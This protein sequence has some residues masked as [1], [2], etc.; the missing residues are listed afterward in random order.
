MTVLERSVLLPILAP[1]FIVGLLLGDMWDAPAGAVGLLTL[2][3]VLLTALSVSS[4]VS[5]LP[6]LAIGAALLGLL[7]GGLVEQPGTQLL[8]YHDLSG[9]AV[10]GLVIDQP[11]DH[12]RV[13]SFRLKVDQVRR[14]SDASWREAV[15]DVRVTAIPTL[16]LAQVRDTPL[17][18]Y[19]DRLELRGRFE[20]PTP[21]GEFD[22]PAFL[23][24]QGISTVMAFP[25]VVLI[26]E[27]GG[28]PVRRWLSSLRIALSGSL[29]RV[30]SEPQ[31]AFGQA[32]LLGMRDGLPDSLTDDFRR[33]G[34]SHLLAISGLHVGMV[35]LFTTSLSALVFGRRRGLYLMLPLG[36]IWLYAILSG[37]SPSAMRASAMGTVYLGAIAV[38]RPGTLTPALALAAIVLTSIE[39]RILYSISFQL[40]F[41]AMLGIGVYAERTSEWVDDRL[42]L[43]PESGGIGTAVARAVVGTIGITI[44]ATLAT[45]PLVGLYFGQ[46]SLVGLPT[47]LLTLTAVPFALGFHAAASSVGMVSDVSAMPFGWLAWLF[48]S[49]VIGVVSTLARIPGSTISVGAVG[50]V[51]VWVYY[52]ALAAL[53]VTA[54]IRIPWRSWGA[55]IST[56]VDLARSIL[57]PWPVVLV[58]CAAA[59]LVWTSA[60]NQQPRRLRVVFADVGQ[61]DM[62]V[63]TTPAGNTIVVDGGPDRSRAAEVLGNLLPFWDRTL[64]LLVLTHPHE[65][66]ITGLN[67]VLKR[68]TVERVLERRL[69]FEGPEYAIWRNLINADG[70][71]AISAIPNLTVAFEDGVSIEVVGPAD[72]LL[73]GTRSDVNNASVIVRVV[74]GSRS[75]LVTGDVFSE[76]ELS[77]VRS[78]RSLASDV[79][80]VAHH[81]SLTSSSQM[82]INAVDPTAV[83][84][85]V[86]A[87]NRFGHPHPDVIDRLEAVVG[88]S[89]VFTTSERGSVTFE[90]DGETI[91]VATER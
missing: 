72:P 81:G 42:G 56:A 23:E 45:A 61:G 90:T 91:W 44:A 60:L 7:R 52:A 36:A 51:L 22:Y 43:R 40:S 5:L 57:L 46:L 79:L 63:I 88:Q 9:L 75:F 32:I 19:G 82:M 8:I 17:F 41:A 35:L 49:Y 69:S 39:P 80:K 27:G 16:A 18:R 14:N 37:A 70:A 24:R 15:G 3:A 87:D 6:A 20:A 11:L 25:D 30:V 48:S 13:H 86:G 54:S 38:G 58:V 78:G 28:L 74:Y 65:D 68:Y 34:A 4:R 47:T 89:N 64:E 67:E 50:G 71:Q 2:A 1:A 10:Q 21:I 59:V 53:M 55:G 85:S 84:V 76:G 12:G 29:E 83:V 62:T 26:S 66:H 33:T 31:A 73:T 77:V